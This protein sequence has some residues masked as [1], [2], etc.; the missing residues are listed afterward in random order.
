[1]MQAAVSMGTHLG[2]AATVAKA[3][4]A[5]T[6]AQASMVR[7]LWNST[8]GYFRAYTGGDAVMSDAL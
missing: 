1:M 4:A 6:V 3:Q 5:I 8:L 2:D 7:L